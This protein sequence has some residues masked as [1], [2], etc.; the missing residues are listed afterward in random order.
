MNLD[1]VTTENGALMIPS[2]NS[3]FLEIF[4]KDLVRG[5]NPKLNISVNS[6]KED[7]V[8]SILLTF[9]SRSIKN[10]VGER[11][12]FYD[13]YYQL[14]Q[15]F[16]EI[17]VKLINFI[18][19]PHTGGSWNDINR[20]IEYYQNNNDNENIKLFTKECIE[21]YSKTLSEDF[22]IYT[23]NS[24]EN[25]SLCAKYAPT[26]KTHFWNIHGKEI[27]KRFYVISMNKSNTRSHIY[28]YYRNALSSLREKIKVVERLM[29]SKN[30]S[31]I[32]FSSVPSVAMNIYS[33]HAFPNIKADNSQRFECFDRIKCAENFSKFKE[34]LIQGTAK[35]NG[36]VLGLDAFGKEFENSEDFTIV[37]SQFDDLLDSLRNQSE[38][39]F[40]IGKVLSIVDVSG[41]MECKIGNKCTAMQIA[42]IMGLITSQINSESPFFNKVL[43]FETKPHWV[44]LTECESYDKKYSKIKKSKW[45]YSTNFEEALKMFLAYLVSNK[46]SP[47]KVK[48]YKI[49][50]LSDMQ[51]N[52]AYDSR[53]MSFFE[54]ME[55][56][57]Y[58]KG[59]EIPTIIFWN[60]A[61]RD[62]Q[63]T[64]V[65]DTHKNVIMVSGFGVGQMKA[66]LS[67]KLENVSPLDKMLEVL[68]SDAFAEI[69]D[70]VISLIN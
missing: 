7:I 24:G 16:P 3:H 20:M 26:E 37:N 41:S 14:L 5:R 10:G 40:D 65:N 32:N 11:K 48:G 30:W 55:K 31:E 38:K 69:K 28:K 45:G 22:I 18:V 59:Y 29:C 43:T 35:V 68:Y 67:G 61:A 57:Y 13:L 60:L 39:D 15:V 63:G 27:A 33:K 4:S 50:C 12:I 19:N 42:I 2:L 51:F 34:Q 25:I 1:F 58:A 47:E 46:I 64:V 70:K 53:N 44:D 66:I 52:M 23:K 62:T 9:Y 6:S 21:Y 49:L 36:S 54:K 8:L 56:A 17:M